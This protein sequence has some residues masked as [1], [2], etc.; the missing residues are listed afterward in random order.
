MSR[1]FTKEDEP[2]RDG[3]AAGAGTDDVGRIH[4]SAP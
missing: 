4:V 2:E 3:F 1:A